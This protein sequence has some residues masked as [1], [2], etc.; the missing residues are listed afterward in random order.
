[1]DN[2]DKKA[3]RI[4]W[5]GI[6]LAWIGFVFIFLIDAAQAFYMHGEM[7]GIDAL[8]SA[9]VASFTAGVFALFL[10]AVAYGFINGDV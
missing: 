6:A 10:G 8:Q 7:A 4:A 1:M 9:Y 5:G 2:Q 3:V